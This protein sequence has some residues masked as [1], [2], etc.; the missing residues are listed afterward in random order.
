MRGSAYPPQRLGPG[1][2]VLRLLGV[3][4][5]HDGPLLEPQVCEAE[6]VVVE[7]QKPVPADRQAGG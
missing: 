5:Q 4:D 7:R 6:Q 3:G 2:H 1:V